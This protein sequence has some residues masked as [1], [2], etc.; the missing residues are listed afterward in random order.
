MVAKVHGGLESYLSVLEV[1]SRGRLRLGL[2]VGLKL[3]TT[4][5]PP[6]TRGA[7]G[8]TVIIGGETCPQVGRSSLIPRSTGRDME[9]R[10]G[11]IGWWGGGGHMEANLPPH[12]ECQKACQIRAYIQVKSHVVAICYNNEAMLTE[13]MNSP[14]DS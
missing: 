2:R 10:L 1:G 11:E 7:A 8:T 13:D 12:P 5:R 14:A 3:T 4:P 9:M 6:K